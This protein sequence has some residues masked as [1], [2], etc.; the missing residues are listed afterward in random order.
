MFAKDETKP[1][2][3]VKGLILL[4]L[5]LRRRDSIE[6]QQS[7]VSPKHIDQ[8]NWSLKNLF[9]H[10]QFQRMSKDWKLLS[11]EW[12]RGSEKAGSHVRPA[13]EILRQTKPADRP[14]CLS[15]RWQSIAQTLCT[16]S[17]THKSCYESTKTLQLKHFFPPT[18]C[19]TVS[20][21]CVENHTPNRIG[22]KNTC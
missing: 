22:R 19:A 11:Q 14:I 18:L 4:P 1:W 10:F 2:P 8:T 20:A 9:A 17:G 3:K 15:W 5:R 21:H 6:L 12:R 16:H 13:R 7:R